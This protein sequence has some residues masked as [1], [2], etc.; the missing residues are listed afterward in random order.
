MEERRLQITPHSSDLDFCKT[1]VETAVQKECWAEDAWYW[2]ATP[3]RVVI[4]RSWLRSTILPSFI[5]C[6]IDLAIY[7]CEPYARV[8]V[9]TR[10]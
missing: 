10:P 1:S 4:R 8:L 6:A 5:R 7:L 9:A 2:T 3:T